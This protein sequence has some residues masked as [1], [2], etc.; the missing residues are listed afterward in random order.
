MARVQR[1]L[2]ANLM[3]KDVQYFDEHGT[4]ALTSRLTSDATLLGSILT[5]NL[6]LVGGAQ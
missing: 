1:V 2:L 4:G 6:N 5:T 3:R